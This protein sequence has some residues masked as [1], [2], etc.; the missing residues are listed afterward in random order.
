MLC[1]S[2][3]RLKSPGVTSA[4]LDPTTSANSSLYLCGQMRDCHSCTWDY[5]YVPHTNDPLVR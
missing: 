2:V 3:S 5:D 1:N 4:F